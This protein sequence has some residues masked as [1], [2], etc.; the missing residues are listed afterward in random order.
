MGS[1]PWMIR[2]GVF[3]SRKRTESGHSYPAQGNATGNLARA[4]D[5]PSAL[6]DCIKDGGQPVA[7]SW[8]SSVVRGPPSFPYILLPSNNPHHGAIPA[9]GFATMNRRSPGHQCFISNYRLRKI[10]LEQHLERLFHHQVN[11]KAGF[12]VPKTLPRQ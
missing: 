2:D 4:P 10:D 12:I 5:R 1:N 6:H 9:T 3:V 7:G 11:A 8:R